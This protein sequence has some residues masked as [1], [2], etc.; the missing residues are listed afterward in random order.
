MHRKNPRRAAALLA[1]AVCALGLAAALLLDGPVRGD[2]AASKPI[3]EAPSGSASASAPAD[4]PLTLSVRSAPPRPR[5]TPK[6]DRRA[7]ERLLT[8]VNRTARTIW[9]AVAN[10]PKHHLAAT[11]WRL[12][13]GARVSVVLPAHWDAR[14]WGRTGCSFDSAGRGH[15]V[16]GDCGG[17]FQ[18]GSRWGA[19]PATLGEFNLDAWQDMDF[20][21]VSLVDGSNLPMYINHTGGTPD[22]ISSTG[23][24]SAGCTKDANDT[25]PRTLRVTH[26]G[27]VV[28]CRSACV[29]LNT[30][31]TCCRGQW[32]P[33][34][35]CR[36]SEWPI[37]SAAL[38]KHAEPAAYSYV[39]DDATS[40]FTCKGSCDY[41]ITFGRSP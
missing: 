39:N 7:G 21:D 17:R 15:C 18:C 22:K 24:V 33:R 40:V 23:C 6:P 4:A 32:A 2:R 10:D 28:A 34:S 12:E 5:K 11:G 25:C 27:A 41:R 35:R 3:A 38:F 20:Y 26:D 36:P 30:D 31:Q 8:L 29:A 16:T 19:L 9:P 13:P 37:D 14:V 1:A